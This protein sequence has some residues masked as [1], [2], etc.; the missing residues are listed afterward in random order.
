MGSP[1][2]ARHRKITFVPFETPA[3]AT[4]SL[5]RGCFGVASFLPDILTD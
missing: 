2:F 3:F 1:A 4:S 5:R